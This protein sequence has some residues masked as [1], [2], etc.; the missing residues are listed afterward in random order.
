MA[1]EDEA[2]VAIGDQLP[3]D[4]LLRIYSDFLFEDFL[5]SYEKLFC[6]RNEDSLE[7]PA[8]YTWENQLYRNFMMRLLSM[9]EPRKENKNV[10]IYN[11]LDEVNEVIFFNKGDYD[12]GF[13]INRERYFVVRYQ[14]NESANIIGAYGVTFN[15]RS[16]FI[17]RTAS[18]CE[19]CSVR[20]TK[21]MTLMEDD[22]HKIISYHL[23]KQL[24][25][26]YEKKLFNRVNDEKIKK[27]K[28]W[29]KRADY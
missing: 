5:E 21:W 16:K 8:F 7:Q 23:K 14:N 11:E 25:K 28:M 6:F 24:K 27:L 29:G 22:D 13:E 2:D 4:V 20:K 10:T 1:F 18:F 9:L 17:Y 19:G 26:D 12:V 3:A 15:I